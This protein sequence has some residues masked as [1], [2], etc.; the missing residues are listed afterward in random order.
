M[1]V[2]AGRLRL[3][4][5]VLGRRLLGGRLL[6]L[7]VLVLSRRLLRLV[8]MLLLRDGAE[9]G[10]ECETEDSIHRIFLSQRECL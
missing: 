1:L 10:D 7:A 6:R 8:L 9:G 4:V 2:L 5:L 3:A